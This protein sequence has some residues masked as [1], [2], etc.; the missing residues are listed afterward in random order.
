[1]SQRIRPPLIYYREQ[2]TTPG[3]PCSTLCEWCVGSFTSHRV[4][5]IEGLR[6]GANGFI[7]LIRDADVITEAALYP[8]LSKDPGCWA[9]PGLA[10]V[11]SL[12]LRRVLPPLSLPLRQLPSNYFV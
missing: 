2:T 11:T 8:Q 4:I 3:T 7:A 9:W 6:D 1:M 12:R 5:S 10:M